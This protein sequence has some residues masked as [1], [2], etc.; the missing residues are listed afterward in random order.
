MTLTF[1]DEEM[2]AVIKAQNE[3][4]EVLNRLIRT[5]RVEH[6]T[7]TTNAKKRKAEDERPEMKVLLKE[8][9]TAWKR[10]HKLHFADLVKILSLHTD[11]TDKEFLAALKHFNEMEAVL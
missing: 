1:N 7:A 11:D 3:A 8:F 6:Y 9:G 2:M 4:N 5:K 10:N